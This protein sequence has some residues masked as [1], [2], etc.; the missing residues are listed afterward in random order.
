MLSLLNFQRPNC[1]QILSQKQNWFL[2]LNDIREEFESQDK[3]SFQS[4]FYEKK[5]LQFAED[6]CINF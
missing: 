3:D 1:E 6:F 4:L 5:K 2:S